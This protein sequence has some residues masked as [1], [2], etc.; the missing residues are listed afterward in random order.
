MH[1]EYRLSFK[2]VLS[3]YSV[4]HNS[5]QKGDGDGLMVIGDGNDDGDGDPAHS[6]MMERANGD[7]DGDGDG[8][9]WSPRVKKMQKLSKGLPICVTAIL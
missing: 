8:D 3:S 9:K 1:E 2:T 5:T 6:P 7:G 4:K